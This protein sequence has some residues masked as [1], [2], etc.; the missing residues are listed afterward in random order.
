MTITPP[1]H[2][3]KVAHL[4]DESLAGQRLDRVIAALHPELSR[5]AASELIAQDRVR[6]NGQPAKP[7]SRPIAGARI[8]VDLPEP[9]QSDA[10][11]EAIPLE[12][13][14]EDAALVVVNKPAG[15]VVHPAPGDLTGTLVNALLGRY[16]GLPGDSGRP[17]IV[18]RLDKDTSGL[19]VVARTP[20]AL[21]ALAG[22]FKRH[23][24]HKE[25]LSLLIGTPKPEAGAIDA[26][27]GRDPRHRQQMAVVSTGGRESR[28]EYRTEERFSGYALVR[29]LPETGR[30]HQIRVHFAAKGHPVAG[31]ALYGRPAPKLGLRRQ[32]LHAAQLRF[33]H[34]TTGET[35]RF[36]APLAAD[37]QH[38]V[39]L[40]RAAERR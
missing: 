23:Q 36:E 35:M 14:Y 16:Q 33:V 26:P 29:A 9:Q 32:F 17:G 12:V 34:P 28:T 37:L 10:G 40:L 25:Y 6:I 13:I 20:Q 4:L 21:A 3:Q 11:P 8:T 31:D 18:H 27:I 5:A 19:I 7:A 38:A 22:A 2:S 24:V 30:M 1:A 39:D 15:M